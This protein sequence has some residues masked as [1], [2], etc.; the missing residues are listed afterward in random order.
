MPEKLPFYKPENNPSTRLTKEIE[1]QASRVK[2]ILC[3]AIQE[4]SEHQTITLAI[5][6]DN[7]LT[8][9]G[10]TETKKLDE[11]IDR[12]LFIFREMLEGDKPPPTPDESK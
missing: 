5:I 1:K 12:R 2:D 7:L 6:L 8:L 3:K 11:L 4:C 9:R 10:K